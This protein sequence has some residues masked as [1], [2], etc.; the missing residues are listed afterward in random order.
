LGVVH[1]WRLSEHVRFGL[2]G[3]YAVNRVPN[4]LEPIYGGDPDGG[5]VFIR[6]KID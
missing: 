1:D 4:A 5:M 6:L 2:G 3:L